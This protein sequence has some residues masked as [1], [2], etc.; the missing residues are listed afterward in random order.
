MGESKRLE[1]SM[2]KPG[3]GRRAAVALSGGVDSSTVAALLKAEGFELIGLTM[4]LWDHG[5]TKP[6]QSRTCCALE[7]VHDARRVAQSLDIPFYVVNLEAEFKQAVVDD[8]IAAYA[9]GRTPNPCIRC[10]QKLKFQ[11]LLAKALDLDAEFLATGHYARVVTLNG[12][13]QLR[14]GLDLSKDQ[15]YFLFATTPTD[16]SHIRF[17][18]GEMSKAQTRQAAHDYGLHIA[19]KSES[20]DLCFVPDGD[21][22]A[23]F[24]KEGMQANCTPGPIVD[25]Q[26]RYLGEHKGVGCYTIGQRKGLGLSAP[27]P[28]Y[29]ITIKSST[30]CLVVG[31]PSALE[32]TTLQVEDLHWL[33]ETPLTEPVALSAQIRYASTAQPVM[34]IPIGEKQAQVVFD[35]PQRAIA[36]GPAC[37]F[38]SADRVMGG[39]WIF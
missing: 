1:M 29:V 9:M 27:E 3:R 12:W 39:G 17:P 2:S 33:S 32:Q 11:N 5:N 7:D 35:T 10:N 38:Y 19:E 16:L 26:G 14:R 31:P 18:L 13:P 21:Y 30:N 22:E 24:L 36:P 34:V 37:V 23:F 20:Q 4:Q 6:G 25:L 28:L 15:S 8:F